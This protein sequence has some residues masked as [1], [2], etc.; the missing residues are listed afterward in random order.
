MAG[1]SS[2]TQ[3]SLPIFDGKLFEDWKVNMLAVFG[4]QDVFEV[5][6]IGFQD[7]G[8]NATEE[9]KLALKQ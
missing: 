2:I 5:V 6:I 1:S 7:P 8:K 4:F 9:Q 3:G